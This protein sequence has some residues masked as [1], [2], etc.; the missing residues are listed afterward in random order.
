MV[1]IRP[2]TVDLTIRGIER[3]LPKST[4]GEDLSDRTALWQHLVSEMSV[5]LDDRQEGTCPHGRA[6]RV[7]SQIWCI[8]RHNNDNQYC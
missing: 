6:E 1:V 5:S 8:R 2:K 3:A 7:K 4:F